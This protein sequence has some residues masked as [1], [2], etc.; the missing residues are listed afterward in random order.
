MQIHGLSWYGRE[1]QGQSSAASML[2]LLVWKWSN[3]TTIVQEGILMAERDFRN[4]KDGPLAL[5]FFADQ[6]NSE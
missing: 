2:Y 4:S 6:I 5:N 3:T 1:P